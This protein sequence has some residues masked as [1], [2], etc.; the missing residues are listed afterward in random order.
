MKQIKN[1]EM[2]GSKNSGTGSGAV[3]RQMLFRESQIL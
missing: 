2:K 3:K 1:G